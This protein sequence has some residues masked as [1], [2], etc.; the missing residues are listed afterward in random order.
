MLLVFTLTNAWLTDP[1]LDRYIPMRISR[2]I[3][4]LKKVACSPQ[5]FVGVDI[6]SALLTNSRDTHAPHA[7]AS[8]Q[9]AQFK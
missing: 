7:A 4:S 5:A 2:M 6:P 8:I 3:I 1:D 9:L